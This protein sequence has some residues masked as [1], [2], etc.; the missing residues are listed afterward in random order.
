MIRN[1]L[2]FVLTLGALAW[3]VYAGMNLVNF[4]ENSNPEKLFGSEDGRIFILNRPQ[5]IRIEGTDFILQPRLIELY[6]ILSSTLRKGERIYVSEKKAHILLQTNNLLG[7]DEIMSRFNAI[8]MESIGAK[9]YKWN[10]FKISFFKGVVDC[11]I[12]SEKTAFNNIKWNTFDK[13]SSCSIIEFSNNQSIV[14]DFYQ[15]NGKT[16]IY[17]RQPLFSETPKSYD[18]QTLY[19]NYIPSS[20]RTYHFIE[21]TFLAKKDP[22]FVKNDAF[23]WTKYGVVAFEYN[24]A[25]FLLFDF[26]DGYEPE[27]M[28]ETYL[29][30]VLHQ[31]KHFTGVQLTEN[32]PI[33]NKR[34]FYLKQIDN[35]VLVSDTENA[36]SEAEVALQLDQTLSRYRKKKNLIFSDAPQ[37]VNER[38]WSNEGKSARSSYQG[39]SIGMEVLNSQKIQ[40]SIPSDFQVKNYAL[41]AEVVDFIVDSNKDLV[42]ALSKDNFIS[43]H[44]NG[45]SNFNVKVSDG[46]IGTLFWSKSFS[47]VAIFTSSNKLY[48]VSQDGTNLPGFP[49]EIPGGVSKGAVSFIWKGKEN[50]L[51]PSNDGKYYWINEKGGILKTGETALKSIAHL[52]DV[53]TSAKRLFFGFRDDSNFSMIEAEK[54]TQLRSFPLTK[55]AVSV[56]LENE[57]NFFDLEANAL[58]QLDQKGAKKMITDIQIPIWIKPISERDND[59][60]LIKT[61]NVIS[62]Y[63]QEGKFKMKVKIP[64][65]SVDYIGYSNS[66]KKGVLL[67][68]IDGLSNK[69]YLYQLNGFK[70]TLPKNQAQKK[71]QL[72]NQGNNL[73]VYTII[74]KFVIQ[75]VL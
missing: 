46:V 75:Y 40:Q 67:G 50:Y 48:L 54:G 30:T 41:S 7:E 6:G 68:I 43:G 63:S 52:P 22:V 8:G 25:N 71:Y 5:E 3:V 31:H 1:F 47:N 28:L 9:K 18:D 4:S 66:I 12:E 13:K 34:G 56:C 16:T 27:Q 49:V 55:N 33:N 64:F 23:T 32:F 51:V 19:G 74:D 62:Y 20:V 39:F 44:A 58:I 37:I 36:L 24:G 57:I 65:E 53:W 35:Y 61:G 45:K 73:V 11:Q 59:G 69:I 42:F 2:F 10:N 14:K 38:T 29:D 70:I 21:K 15:S 72:S 17:T 60:F 26:I